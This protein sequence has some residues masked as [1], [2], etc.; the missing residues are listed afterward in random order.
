MIS[1]GKSRV[2]GEAKTLAGSRLVWEEARVGRRF[3]REDM[4][5][6]LPSCQAKC[7]L[8]VTSNHVS[9]PLGSI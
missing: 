5:D 8:L 3:A 1:T 7:K 2:T 6:C 4:E 9:R